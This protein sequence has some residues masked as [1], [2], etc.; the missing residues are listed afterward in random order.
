M[1]FY[2]CFIWFWKP[3]SKIWKFIHDL[4]NLVKCMYHKRGSIRPSFLRDSWVYVLDGYHLPWIGNMFTSKDFWSEDFMLIKCMGILSLSSWRDN[5]RDVFGFLNHS[6]LKLGL[7]EDLSFL[8]HDALAYMDKSI[9]NDWEKTL[10]FLRH[11]ALACVDESII[12]DWLNVQCPMT[13]RSSMIN[14]I[15]W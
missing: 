1:N 12:N 5:L 3:C 8:R 14:E 9:I 13:N 6:G 4:E 10:S 2:F 7:G 15:F 11:N